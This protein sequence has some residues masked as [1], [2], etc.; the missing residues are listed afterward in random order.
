MKNTG[1]NKVYDYYEGT[2]DIVKAMFYSIMTM[3]IFVT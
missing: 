3:E 1:E 2:L